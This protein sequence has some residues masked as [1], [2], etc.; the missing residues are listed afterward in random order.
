M[1]IKKIHYSVKEACER[2]A[3]KDYRFV[4][5]QL[6]KIFGCSTQQYYY[7]KRRDFVNMP[8]HIRQKVEELFMG[9]GF[10]KDEIFKTWEDE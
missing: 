2:V 1:A 10:K 8:E 7:Q 6:Q 9:L 4:N 3:V 5:E